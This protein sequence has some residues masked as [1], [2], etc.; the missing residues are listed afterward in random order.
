MKR[1]IVAATALAVLAG[2]AQAAAPKKARALSGGVAVAKGWTYT[3]K[4]A[5]TGARVREACTVS[6]N[7]AKLSFPYK[8]TSVRLCITYVGDEKSP[9][10]GVSFRLGGKGQFYG[11]TVVVRFDDGP[12][13][14]FHGSGSDEYYPIGDEA[15]FVREMRRAKTLT[16]QL[17]FFD[18]G[19]QNLRFNV[20]GLTYGPAGRT[21]QDIFD[22]SEERRQAAGD[23]ARIDAINARYACIAQERSDCPTVKRPEKRQRANGMVVTGPQAWIVSE[24]GDTYFADVE[25]DRPVEGRYSTD[26]PKLEFSCS[27]HRLGVEIHWADSTKSAS[28][29]NSAMIWK[30]D[31]QPEKTW[32]WRSMGLGGSGAP[33]KEWLAAIEKG[34]KLTV[35]VDGQKGLQESSFDLAGIDEIA[36]KLTAS[37]GG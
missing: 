20:A 14:V 6:E 19:S 17:S 4:V 18:D 36:R 1:L 9:G 27:G 13:Q 28:P 8:P 3:D 7:Q 25:G 26:R 30:L 11:D 21:T 12:E 29:L 16:A 37:C 33:A 15:A 34:H 24:S 23:Q 22:R 31:D 10:V 2:T 32:T 35:R 5:D